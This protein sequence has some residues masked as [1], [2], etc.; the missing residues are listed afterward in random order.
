MCNRKSIRFS[1]TRL[2]YSPQQTSPNTIKEENKVVETSTPEALPVDHSPDSVPIE[3]DVSTPVPTETIPAEPIIRFRRPVL[4]DDFHPGMTDS[5][6][7][8]TFSEVRQLDAQSDA[9]IQLQLE[10]LQIVLG[11]FDETDEFEE[12]DEFEEEWEEGVG[13][14][15]YWDVEAD[16]YCEA[17]DCGESFLDDRD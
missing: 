14:E 9:D 1:N 15:G 10:E 12:V 6:E 16:G 3:R 17:D 4:A 8:L 13:V 11:D 5:Y 2:I 7:A